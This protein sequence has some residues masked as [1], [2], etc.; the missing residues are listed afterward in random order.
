MGSKNYIADTEAKYSQIKANEECSE[1]RKIY[2][3]FT[4]EKFISECSKTYYF[5]KGIDMGSK[6]LMQAKLIEEDEVKCKV[7][8]EEKRLLSFNGKYNGE[9]SS[10]ECGN[11]CEYAII[12]F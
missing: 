11:S 6:D 10:G 7:K 2:N 12:K 3:N 5:Y 9:A 4:G 1:A 8:R